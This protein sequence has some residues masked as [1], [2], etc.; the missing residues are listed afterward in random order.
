MN[1]ATARARSF[2]P[3]MPI[4]VFEGWILSHV[5]SYGWPFVSIHSSTSM[6]RWQDFFLGRKLIYF[7]N[8]TWSKSL[9]LIDSFPLHDDSCRR[10]KGLINH[11]ASTFK[12]GSWNIKDS[13][14]RL[15]SAREFVR[16]NKTIPGSLVLVKEGASFIICD[17]HHRI[18]ALVQSDIAKTVPIPVWVG[19]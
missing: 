16:H 2:F 11:C 12:T 14:E 8:L 7:H 3:Q 18:A 1:D 15:A 17:G 4:E 10:L 6:T 5:G 13:V 9:A 19:I